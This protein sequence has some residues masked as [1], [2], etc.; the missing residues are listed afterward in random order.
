MAN[1]IENESWLCVDENK[2]EFILSEAMCSKCKLY[3]TQVNSYGIIN[4][5]YCP[6]CGVR[7]DGKEDG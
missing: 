2:I 4:Y 3:S 6:R 7:M 5:Q 1:W